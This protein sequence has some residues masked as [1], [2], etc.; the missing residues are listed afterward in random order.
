MRTA[1][2][3]LEGRHPENRENST[4]RDETGG[5]GYPHTAPEGPQG[6][7]PAPPCYTREGSRTVAFRVPLEVFAALEARGKPGDVARAIVL[8]SLAGGRAGSPSPPN[9]PTGPCAICAAVR[10]A[11]ASPLPPGRRM[12]RAL[13][14]LEARS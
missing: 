10:R 11:L 1:R 2:D 14:L 7:T 4:E 9:G 13:E 3:L 12:E 5:R 8:E 6:V